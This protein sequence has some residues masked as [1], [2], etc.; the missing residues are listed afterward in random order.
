MNDDAIPIIN[1]DFPTNTPASVRVKELHRLWCYYNDTKHA[2]EQS[3]RSREYAAQVGTG[4]IRSPL[5]S[6][7]AQK[8]R[9]AAIPILKLAVLDHIERI[10]E[11]PQKAL[12][13][14]TPDEHLNMRWVLYSM[15]QERAREAE[16]ETLQE[17]HKTPERDHGRNR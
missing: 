10:E 2:H 5:D 8:E 3:E 13:T 14:L 12:K 9:A 16:L 4:I 15:R 1:R 7:K 11:L 17:Q 6:P